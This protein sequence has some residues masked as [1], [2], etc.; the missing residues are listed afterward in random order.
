MA[1]AWAGAADA[2]AAAVATRFGGEQVRLRLGPV[3]LLLE[4]LFELSLLEARR[5]LTAR[6]FCFCRGEISPQVCSATVA[7]AD[8]RGG[9]C[10][11][12]SV[13]RCC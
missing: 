4:L 9:G 12:C 3:L 10:C 6:L 1:A 8:P 5:D 2:E 11:R 7:A 13:C